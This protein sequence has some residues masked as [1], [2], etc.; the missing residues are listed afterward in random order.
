MDPSY[1]GAGTDAR[2]DAKGKAKA[3][4]PKNPAINVRYGAVYRKDFEKGGD[5]QPW[6]E[7]GARCRFLRRKIEE[8]LPAT[9]AVV[10][11]SLPA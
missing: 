2:T 9:A 8:Q 7:G 10:V 5:T 6:S 11:P 1:F 3:N 4:T